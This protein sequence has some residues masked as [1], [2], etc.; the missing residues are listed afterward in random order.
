MMKNQQ[1]Q[2]QI[3]QLKHDLDDL[4]RQYHEQV[5][6]IHQRDETIAHLE[7]EVEDMQKLIKDL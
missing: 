4:D 3:D 6:I 1:L 2:D 7:H 5:L